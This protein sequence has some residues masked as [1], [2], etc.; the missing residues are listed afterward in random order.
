MSDIWEAE[1]VPVRCACHGR[2]LK[3]PGDFCPCDVC[4]K[5]SSVGG[6]SGPFC[7]EHGPDDLPADDSRKIQQRELKKWWEKKELRDE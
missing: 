3:G 2:I 5:P 1:G 7:S 4:G 6:P